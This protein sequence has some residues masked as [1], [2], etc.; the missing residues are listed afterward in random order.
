MP[1]VMQH[2]ENHVAGEQ[3]VGEF[4]DNTLLQRKMGL[5]VFR[6]NFFAWEGNLFD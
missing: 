6:K 2:I 4:V 3:H 1:I 5:D